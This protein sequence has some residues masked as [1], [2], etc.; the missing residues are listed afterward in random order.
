VKQELDRAAADTK[1]RSE[2]LDPF[3]RL[4]SGAQSQESIAHIAQAQQQSEQWFE[5]AL[6]KIEKAAAEPPLKPGVVAETELATEKPTVKP[7]CTIQPTDF[8]TATYLET[9]QDVD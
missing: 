1:L 7:H 9:Q 2:C 8:L 4:R 6:T 3:D 5:T